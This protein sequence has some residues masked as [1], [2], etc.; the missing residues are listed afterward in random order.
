MSDTHGK[1]KDCSTSMVKMLSVVIP[2]RDEEGCI[3]STVE[4]LHLELDL[5]G[6]PHEIIVVDDGSTDRTWEILEEEA[7]RLNGR[8]AHTADGIRHEA[9]GEGAGHEARGKRLEAGSEGKQEAGDRG[10]GGAAESCGL[11][12]Q[13]TKRPRDEETGDRGQ[14][15]EVGGQMSEGGERRPVLRPIKNEG[16]HGFGRAI[17]KG[18]DAMTGDAVVIMMADESDDCRD[19][20][21]YWEKLNEGYD[22]VF[23]SRFMKGGGTIDYPPIKLFMNRMANAF[24][25]FMFRHGLNDTTNAFKAYRKEVID[26][27]RPILS[28]H[29]NI[30]VELPL[31]AIVRGYSFTVI[32]ITWRNRRHGVAKLKIKEMGSRYLFICL[33]VW[34]EKY[35]SRGDYK[36][37]GVKVADKSNG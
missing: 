29:F 17:V 15:S 34:L 7:A 32:P 9:G 18:L 36:K 1:R 19:V 31:K 4:H 16:P 25:R 30:T 5:R 35:F 20:V 2:A 14:R 27:I 12:D 37:N 28:P 13:E 22:C 11:K 8:T 33:Y 21:R 10:R 26:G 3:A 24:V 23:G 6:V